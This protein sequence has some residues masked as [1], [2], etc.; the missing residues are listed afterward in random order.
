[1]ADRNVQVASIQFFSQIP[2]RDDAPLTQ[3]V[4][5]PDP[6][7]ARFVAV[8]VKPVT[9][10]T[11]LPAGLIGGSNAVTTGAS[12]VAGFDQVVRRFPPLSVCNPSETDGMTYEGAPAALQ[13]ATADPTIRRRLIRLHQYR[14]ANEYEAGDYGFL[15]SSSLGRGRDALIDAL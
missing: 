10:G 15:E 9:L 2:A 12:R 5:A 6:T 8:T 4:A 1:G 13:A 11:I 7:H 14:G 3:A